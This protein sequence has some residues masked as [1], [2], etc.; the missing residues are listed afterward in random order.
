MSLKRKNKNLERKYSNGF[1]MLSTLVYIIEFYC[2]WCCSFTSTASET[3]KKQY[4]IKT[5]IEVQ[6]K[7]F[8]DN[9]P[10][11]MYLENSGDDINMTVYGPAELL[12]MIQ[13]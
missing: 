2:Y 1:S 6:A 12:G 11:K 5:F 7:A 10:Y 9:K 13:I 8:A 3:K 4:F